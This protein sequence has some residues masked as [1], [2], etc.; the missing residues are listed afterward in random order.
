MQIVVISGP[1]LGIQTVFQSS[2]QVQVLT[3]VSLLRETQSR[4]NV[5]A[6]IPPVM[7]ASGPRLP[8]QNSPSSGKRSHL[9]SLPP[10]PRP[11][12]SRTSSPPTPRRPRYT[13]ALS[14]GRSRQWAVLSLRLPHSPMRTSPTPS[15]SP[16]LE[17]STREHSKTP[18]PSHSTGLTA[19]W[20]TTSPSPEARLT[21]QQS[22]PPRR[23]R[24]YSPSPPPQ[25]RPRRTLPSPPSPPALSSRPRPAAPSLPPLPVPT[26]SP[27]QDLLQHTHLRSPATPPR[28]SPNLMAG[29]HPLPPRRSAT[30]PK[31]EGSPFQAVQRPPAMHTLRGMWGLGAQRRF[32][33]FLLPDKGARQ[34]LALE[35]CRLARA[36]EELSSTSLGHRRQTSTF[37]L[38][39]PLR[40]EISTSTVRAATTFTLE[41]MALPII[42]SLRAPPAT[43]ALGRRRRTANSPSGARTPQAAPT[44]SSSHPRL[45]RRSSR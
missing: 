23:Q 28:P 34:A 1:V 38:E 44:R 25:A 5:C 11:T 8:L 45:R 9:T 42:S 43:S 13:S 17:V 35:V 21:T 41:R 24:E 15:P 6:S 2:P 14:Q 29:S 18:A 3:Y 16:R 39:T 22:A 7:S 30:A 33:R 26:T 4:M 27:A 19:K 31:R 40:I 20:R 36:T 37:S 32:I 12:P 10:P